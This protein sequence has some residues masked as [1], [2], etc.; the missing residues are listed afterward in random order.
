MTGLFDGPKANTNEKFKKVIHTRMNLF[1]VFLV[2]GIISVVV[3]L[4]AQ[5]LWKISI[6]Q[7]IRVAY[8]GFGGGL[9]FVSLSL[10]VK[11]R[12][13]LA[14]EV[15]LKE[16]RL[17]NTDERNLEIRNKAFMTASTILLISVYA[18][19]LIG[20]LFNPVIWDVLMFLVG[21][22]LIGYLIAYKAYE[23]LL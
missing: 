5:P 9:I 3:V 15:K 19:G 17:N 18:C 22:F 21:I 2:L 4:T 8:I 20:G 13:I 14:D 12:K 1:I 6:R 10:L 11:N 7:D 23:K 16:N